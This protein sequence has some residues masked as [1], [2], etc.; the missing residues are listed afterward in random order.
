MVFIGGLGWDWGVGNP[1]NLPVSVSKPRPPPETVVGSTTP[2][3]SS[4]FRRLNSSSF[5]LP[6]ARSRC[7]FSS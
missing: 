4:T 7:R 2:S 3:S 5:F 1:T 6:A